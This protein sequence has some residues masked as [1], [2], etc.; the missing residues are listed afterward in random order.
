MASGAYTAGAFALAGGGSSSAGT[1]IAGAGIFALNILFSKNGDRFGSSKIGSNQHFNKQFDDF[2]KQY[3]DG[4]LNKRRRFHDYITKKGYDT[5][6]EL[7]KAW[8]EF[9]SRF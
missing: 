6:S 8:Q 3:G 7:L 4:N 1:A 5:W 9:I 2:W